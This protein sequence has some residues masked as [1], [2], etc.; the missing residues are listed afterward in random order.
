MLSGCAKPVKNRVSLVASILAHP[1]QGLT[2][3][4]TGF[5]LHYL[6]PILNPFLNFQVEEPATK[7]YLIASG[8]FSGAYFYCDICCD[9]WTVLKYPT[10][11]IKWFTRLSLTLIPTV[12]AAFNSASAAFKLFMPIWIVSMYFFSL[13][14]MSMVAPVM[15]LKVFL[16]FFSSQTLLR[17]CL[18]LTRLIATDPRLYL[19]ESPI[20]SEP[21]LIEL[22][23]SKNELEKLSALQDL[24]IL[25]RHNDPRRGQIFQLSIPGGKPKIWEA[26]WQEGYSILTKFND[27]ME[28]MSKTKKS[29][30][31]KTPLKSKTAPDIFSTPMAVTPAPGQIVSGRFLWSKQTSTS[32]PPRNCAVP[33][34]QTANSVFQKSGKPDSLTIG[35]RITAFFE[36]MKQAL[37]AKFKSFSDSVSS[38]VLSFRPIE[39]WMVTLPEFNTMSLLANS[40]AV[41]LSMIALAN[42]ISAAPKEDEFGVTL[43]ALPKLLRMLTNITKGLDRLTRN[44]HQRSEL[45]KLRNEARTALGKITAAYGESLE[46]LKLE[47]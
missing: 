26:I 1:L 3:G 34:V 38:Q 15:H 12:E 19:L 43:T 31:P 29:P 47:K 22:L 37:L 7:F 20:A 4:L 10:Y 27:K 45:R 28:E 46:E 41:R 39:F 14:F 40:N 9:N 2:F 8:I 25:S 30:E 24:V 42:I 17:L 6:L 23:K 11:R 44:N 16:L 33:S 13:S 18:S 35:D 36:R 32:S 21:S 5:L